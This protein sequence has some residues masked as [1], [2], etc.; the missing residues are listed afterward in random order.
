MEVI[1]EENVT[2]DFTTH[3]PLT[4]VVQDADFIPTCNVFENSTDVAIISPT[5]TKR[6]GHTGNYRLTFTASSVNGFE[7]GKWYNVIVE[8]TVAAVPAKARV[9]IFG[10]KRMLAIGFRV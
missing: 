9:G 1:L 2:M 3:N 6:V 10:I 4:G 5:V 8:A 7:Q